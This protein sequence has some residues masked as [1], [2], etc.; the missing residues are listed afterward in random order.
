LV[1]FFRTLR[2]PKLAPQLQEQLFLTPY[3]REEFFYSREH[4]EEQE[5]PVERARMWFVVAR[6]CF[7]SAFETGGWRRS[8][9]AH[10]RGMGHVV[11]AYWSSIEMFPELHNRLLGVQIENV[12][13]QQLI[14]GYDSP[15]TFFYL[16]PPYVLD[17]RSGGKQYAKEMTAD[18]HRA[19]IAQ[20]Q[21]I[22]GSV[23][24]SG[25]DHPLYT[26]LVENGWAK[27]EIDVAT[28][29]GL[30]KKKALE[31]RL[32]GEK[33]YGERERRTECLWLNYGVH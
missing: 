16:D 27:I 10:S 13:V 11:S 32:T 7:A 33:M 9:G 5:D 31:Q 3:S 26:P 1:H 15:D 28:T 18:D 17:T 25:Y 22:R 19:F 24:I 6:N 12:P 2:D 30:S 4:W 14:P 21:T 20:V 29:A 23:L 8:T